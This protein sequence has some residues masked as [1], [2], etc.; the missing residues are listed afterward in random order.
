MSLR[1]LYSTSKPARWTLDA[2]SVGL[3]VGVFAV[4]HALPCLGLFSDAPWQSF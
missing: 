3:M 1:D 4:L 2:L